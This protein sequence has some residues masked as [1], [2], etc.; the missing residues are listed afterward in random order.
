MKN[1]K[2]MSRAFETEPS[3]YDNIEAGKYE[4]KVQWMAHPKV[5]KLPS[6]NPTKEDIE[7]YLKEEADYKTK[8]ELVTKQ[9][10]LRDKEE[11]RLYNLFKKEALTELGFEKHPKA[12]LIFDKAWGD[13]HSGGYYEVWNSLMDIVSFVRELEKK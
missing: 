13:G 8:K 1:E 5:P 4:N 9:N 10:E 12:D 7:K 3:I 2:V 11:L 6:L